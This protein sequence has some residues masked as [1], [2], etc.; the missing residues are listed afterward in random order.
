MD[1]RFLNFHTFVRAAR[2][3]TARPLPAALLLLRR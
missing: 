1:R 2:G 3:A